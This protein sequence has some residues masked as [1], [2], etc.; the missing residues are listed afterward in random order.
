MAENRKILIT[1]EI[2]TDALSSGK[3]ISNVLA[4]VYEGEIQD[5]ITANEKLSGMDAFQ[6]AMLD[7]GVTKRSV[8]QDVYQTNGNEWLFPAYIDRRLREAVAGLN[9]LPYLVGSTETVNSMSVQMAKL[10]MDEHNTDAVK[11]KRVAEATDLPLAILHLAD[12]ALSL[13]KRG[14]AVSASYETYMFQ[15]FD[16]FGKHLDMIANDV[17]DQQAGDAI[18]ALINGD[19]N[20]NAAQVINMTGATMTADE[21]L[22]FA[23]AFW[24]DAKLPLTT[25]V[26][27]DIGFYTALMKMIVSD[28]D[29]IGMLPG[30]GFDFPQAQLSK[31]NVLY[32]ARVGTG[33]GNKAQLIGLNTNYALTKYLAAGSQIRELDKNIRNQTNLGTISEIAAFGKLNDGASKILRAV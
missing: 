17:A 33:T 7:A 32:D 1:D 5:K 3:T 22:K 12:A 29:S 4:D 16:M 6:F 27:G 31:L 19:G 20:D 14:R 15:T 24:N 28:N 21:L 8:I 2:V 11:K 30:V 9:I 26:T 23:I 13:K 25:V 18:N 10:V